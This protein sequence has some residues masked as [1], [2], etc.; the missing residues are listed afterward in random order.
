MKL[1]LILIL[2]SIGLSGED[3]KK[4]DKILFYI[5]GHR[6]CNMAIDLKVY[7]KDVSCIKYTRVL[8]FNDTGYV[9]EPDVMCGDLK[10]F[11]YE[12]V[13]KI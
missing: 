10:I 9:S 12:N 8:D 6:V 3:V 4:E 7:K 1:F 2:L 5:C 13:K 11:Y